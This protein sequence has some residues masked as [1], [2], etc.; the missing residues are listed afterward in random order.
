MSSDYPMSE[1]PDPF[2][3]NIIPNSFLLL[4]ENEVSEEGNTFDH[5][6]LSPNNKYAL[7]SRD[8]IEYWNP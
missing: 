7:W 6:E 5:L 1:P 2:A 4:T 8:M 3:T